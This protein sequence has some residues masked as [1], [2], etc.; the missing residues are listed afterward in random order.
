MRSGSRR[1]QEIDTSKKLRSRRGWSS[2]RPGCF[3]AVPKRPVEFS[4]KLRQL[5]FCKNENSSKNTNFIQCELNR[6]GESKAWILLHN[7][8]GWYRNVSETVIND[9]FYIFYSI[10]SKNINAAI[11]RQHW[12]AGLQS[13]I[14]GYK[15]TIIK[16]NACLAQNI[17]TISPIFSVDVQKEYWFSSWASNPAES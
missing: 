8:H 9:Y 5:I 6:Y 17:L 12:F 2:S 10:F 16:I 11:V 3:S 7:E 1:D 13:V 4:R 15:I 14:C